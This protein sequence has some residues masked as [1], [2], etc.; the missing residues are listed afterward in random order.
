MINRRESMTYQSPHPTGASRHAIEAFAES[1]A[2]QYELVKFDTENSDPLWDFV[3]NLGGEISYDD[4]DDI[5]RNED[6]SIIVDGPSRFKIYL[7]HYT[8]ILRDRFTVAHELGHYFLH[9]E[10]GDIPLKATRKG[11]GI[12]EWEANWFGASLLMPKGEVSRFCRENGNDASLVAA[13]FKVSAQAATYR[14]E[15]LGLSA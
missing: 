5:K 9:S 10:Q 14:L 15:H 3:A 6:G 1:L 12:H 4:P 11:T 7:S 2:A 8:G 13:R